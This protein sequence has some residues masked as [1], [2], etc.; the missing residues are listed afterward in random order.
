MTDAAANG[1]NTPD[2]FETRFEDLLLGSKMR[3]AFDTFYT[4]GRRLQGG[5]Y[6]TVFEGTHNVSGREYAIKVVNRK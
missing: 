2:A 1:N 6:G 5:S 3:P 4:L